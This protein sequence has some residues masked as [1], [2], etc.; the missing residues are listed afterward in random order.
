[1]AVGRNTDFYNDV[2]ANLKLL[3]EGTVISIDPSVGSSSSLP[4]YAIYKQGKYIESATIEIDIGKPL[5]L[6]LQEL[7]IRL[8]SLYK[9]VEPDVLVFEDIAPQRYGGGNAEAHASLLK[10]VGAI[11]AIRGPRGYIR[12]KPIVW[13]K[14][15][16]PT[17]VKGDREDAEEMGFITLQLAQQIQSEDPPRKYGKRRTRTNG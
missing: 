16:R 17:Y 3:L 11:L 5:W 6:R 4:A 13:K 7:S 9:F 14:L 15:I 10:A 1:M 12:L 8:R 2:R